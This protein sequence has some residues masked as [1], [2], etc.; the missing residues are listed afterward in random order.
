MK[1]Q[2]EIEHSASRRMPFKLCMTQRP[3]LELQEWLFEQL[4]ILAVALGN[5]SRRNACVFT[6]TTC[7]AICRESSYK[8]R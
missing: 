4:G 7:S 8:L 2:M 1:A 6:L 3:P 5:R